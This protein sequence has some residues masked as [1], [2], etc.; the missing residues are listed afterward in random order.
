LTPLEALNVLDQLKKAAEK[1]EEK[2][3]FK[4]EEDPKE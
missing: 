1:D 2:S 3:Q 4:K